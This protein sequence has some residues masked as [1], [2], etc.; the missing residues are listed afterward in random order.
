MQIPTMWWNLVSAVGVSLCSSYWR[1]LHGS[2]H[3]IFVWWDC[4][5]RMTTITTSVITRSSALAY[6]STWYHAQVWFVCR[7]TRVSCSGHVSW[8][9]IEIPEV[10]QCT[11]ILTNYCRL[12]SP[13]TGQRFVYCSWLSLGD[14]AKLGLR[15]ILYYSL[16]LKLLIRA[17]FPVVWQMVDL[18]Y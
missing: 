6:R 4:G 17:L 11:R 3:T 16:Y 8:P 1:H 9:L 15:P 7:F 18:F 12:L 5:Y 14:S 10:V 2:T 13:N